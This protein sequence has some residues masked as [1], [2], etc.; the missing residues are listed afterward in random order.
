M[1]EMTRVDPRIDDAASRRLAADEDRITGQA[2]RRESL[3]LRGAWREFWRHPSPPMITAAL[4]VAL[5][6]RVLVET[7][8]AWEL[9]VPAT[10]LALFPLIE[11]VVHVVVL[12]WRPRRLGPLTLDSHLAREH[13]A[14][15]APA[16]R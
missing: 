11:W 4:A 13:R 10:L 8:S 12:H 7:G 6:G 9:L 1:T 14:G 2:R 5:T 15:G 3:P 16:A